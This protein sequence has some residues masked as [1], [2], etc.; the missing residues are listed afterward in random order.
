MGQVCVTYVVLVNG[1]AYE[2]LVVSVHDWYDSHVHCDVL[3]IKGGVA[4]G[5]EVK[6]WIMGYRYELWV[7]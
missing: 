7:L 2:F 1:R 4:I 5:C 3:Y 6:L